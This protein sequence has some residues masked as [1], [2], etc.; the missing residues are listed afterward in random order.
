MTCL[1]KA[2]SRSQGITMSSFSKPWVAIPIASLMTCAFAV[3][4]SL[5]FT[6]PAFAGRLN[7]SALQDGGTY[8]R[9]IVRFRKDAPERNSVA[10]RQQSL[11]AAGR[12]HG[13]RVG[14]LRRLA[15]GADV[16]KTDR[17]LG[18]VAAERLM[19]RL[20][21]NPDVEYVELDAIRRPSF[22]PND[23]SYAS[24]W[25]Y[26]EA[27]A[28]INLPAAWDKA[29]GNG[30]V[31]AVIDTG[32]TP[33]SD[34]TPNIVA[35]YDF[36]SDAATA[37][38]GN[39]RDANPNDEGDWTAADDC[40]EGEPAENSSWHG[41]HVAGTI[42]AVTNN[43]KGVAGV[44]F[45]AKVMP[46]RALGKCGGY[47]SDIADAIIWAS[48]GAVTGVPANP[49]PAEVINMSLGGPG[50]CD[51]TSQAAINMAVA[52]GTVVVVAAGN[53]NSDV[54]GF[55]PASCSN[56][57]TVAAVGRNGARAI[58]TNRGSKVDV[59]APGGSSGGTV[60][61]T[62]NS[63]RTTQA[64]ESYAG[65]QGTSMATPHVAGT[66]ALMQSA[67]ANSPAVVEAILKSTARAFPNSCESCGA[68]IIDAS[69]ATTA[70]IHPVLIIGDV[71]VTEG[72]SGTRLATFTV[73]L[74]QPIA[75]VVRYDIAT[76]DGTAYGSATAG[77]DYV[78]S[79]LTGQS[80][81]AGVTSK[82]FTVAINGDTAPEATEPFFVNVTNAVGV[83]VADGQAVGTILNDDPVPVEND[84]PVTEI[85]AGIGQQLLYSFEVPV[86]ASDLTFTTSGG[87]GDVD[88]FVKFGSAPS[89]SVFDCSSTGPTTDETC[90]IPTPQAGT[91]YILLDAYADILGV[92]LT[93]QYEMP[94]LS[95]GPDV[96]IAE[97]NSGTKLATFTVRLSRAS[98]SPVTY[99]IATTSGGSPE[100][101]A[102]SDYVARSLTGET[103]A[104]GQ[105]TKTFTVA[106]NGDSTREPN[107][108]FWV[109]L[110]TVVGADLQLY[111]A[112]GTII[113]DDGPTLSIADVSIT[114]GDK[115][116]R[117][118]TFIVKLSEAAASDVTYDIYT[119]DG[120]AVGYLDY[121]P[122]YLAVETIA[123]GQTSRTFAVPIYGNTR[124]EANKNFQVNLFARAGATIADSQAIGTIV[125]DD[126]NSAII[127]RNSRT[128]ANILWKSANAATTQAMT[129]VTNLAWKIVGIG[130]FDGDSK[131]DVL[132][133]NGSTGANT[134]WKSANAATTQAMTGV[135][136]LAWKIVGVGD[137]DGDG[138]DDVLWRNSS[139]GAN[140]IWRSANAAMTQAMTGVTNLAWKIVGV[141]DFDGDGKDDVLWRNTST[142]ADTIWRSADPATTQAMTGV[143][144]LA[145]KIVG[146]GDFNGDGQ[147]DVLWRNGSSGGNTIWTSANSN[148]LLTI[149][150][151]TNLDWRIVGT[152]DYN[153]DGQADVLWRNV[154]T[155]A[156]T[157]WKS[158]DASTLQSVAAV[159]DLDWA[160]AP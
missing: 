23:P 22:T 63:G 52:A 103:I 32:I 58:Y 110:E 99:D 146:V 126:T 7:A 43:A 14:Q 26:F 117:L 144:N 149:P 30:V 85:E 1:G 91:Y 142:G 159:T 6:A 66:V 121:A 157:I 153:G 131:D 19:Q 92:M 160:V 71:T 4:L 133:R 73:S 155:G 53:D 93:S 67:K 127:W 80:M 75:T 60:L 148:S 151:V 8:D 33:H 62:L 86:G 156:N 132:W 141:G 125:N 111:Y 135:T 122:Q 95:M 68:G 143:T 70:A 102:G 15:M 27:T 11:D 35:G 45:N 41:T 34:L 137:F 13:V 29:T 106:I 100:A 120:T 94:T 44:A 150:G 105:T 128:G 50:T 24:Q 57:I 16:V 82:T 39:G 20:A 134:L 10:A 112:A 104:P 113:N 59:A 87:M 74:S 3:G 83:V 54:S 124:V 49:N 115:G 37:R 119:S 21:R 138:K 5:A 2:A 130:D 107:E 12:G 96:V 140:T 158:A 84:V 136:N 101:T 64:A 65:Y 25:H 123:P 36:I 9:F 89:T 31:V 38:D 48:G 17:K 118:A 116:T 78:A 98:T 28:G 55:S 79:S 18:R 88:L 114:E 81:A 40:G 97:G 56:V 152:G 147:H 72:N 76:A 90:N 69:A 51:A 42:A 129:G 108:P 109:R 46:L 139:T 61:S 77:S 154:S 47:T 145:W